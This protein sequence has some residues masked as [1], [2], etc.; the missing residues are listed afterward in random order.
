[1]ELYYG[2]RINAFWG[3]IFLITTQMFGYGFSGL[4]RDIIVRPPKMY[5]PG[6][7]P[8]VAL[9]NAM[10]HNPA[11]T[12]KALQFFSIVACAAFCYEWFP[13]LIFP[14]LASIPLVC[15]FG[16]GHWIPFVLGSGTYG[17]VSPP[18][19]VNLTCMFPFCIEASLMEG[20]KMVG[21]AGYF[22]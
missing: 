7:L 11:A 9:F 1:M 13:T 2:R 16:H 14:L 17:F 12:R 18:D 21:L 5:Y 6:V 3:I 15:Y 19:L 8:N 4:Y 10:H 20:T 22:T